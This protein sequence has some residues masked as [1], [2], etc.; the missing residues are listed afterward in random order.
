MNPFLQFFEAMGYAARMTVRA[1]G[2]LPTLPGQWDRVLD[3]AF[4]AGYRS[5][6]IVAIMSVFIGGVLALST[7]EG[8][9]DNGL[10]DILGGITGLGMAREL[11]PVMTAFLVAGR[12]GSAMTAE[13]G[14]MSV[15]QEVDALKSMNIPP[16]RCLVLP[17]IVAVLAVMPVLAA[18]SIM[19]G[20]LG[21]ALVAEF[22]TGL[23]L[24][25]EIYWRYLRDWV[26]IV[27]MRA[28]LIKAEA[29]A[30]AIVVIACAL[31]LRTRGGP[32]E[33]G[34]AVTRSVV[35][36]MVAVLLLD[37]CLTKILLFT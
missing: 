17:R 1:A 22:T 15:Y 36:S 33:I 4:R 29:F 24:A 3:Q 27:D 34:A 5:V 32:R 8:L 13:L 14:A 37:Y 26:D 30:L 10:M 23:D 6:P 9:K 16:E 7:A 11:G 19:M 2:F 35:V 28:G 20:W 25:P 31:G 18:I 12:V 21:G